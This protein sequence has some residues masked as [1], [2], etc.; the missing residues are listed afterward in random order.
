MEGTKL[1]SSLKREAF[2]TTNFQLIN[3]LPY[4][5][6]F[7]VMARYVM[8]TQA[9]IPWPRWCRLLP[10]HD[11]PV[12]LGLDFGRPLLFWKEYLTADFL[13]QGCISEIGKNINIL[14]KYASK[15]HV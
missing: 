8:V 7:H 5:M 10:G 4:R 6:K 2:S 1:A 12:E 13:K 9:V 14:C 3:P 11:V 15:I